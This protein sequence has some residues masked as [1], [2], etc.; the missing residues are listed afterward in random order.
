MTGPSGEE[1]AGNPAEGGGRGTDPRSE[2]Q[3]RDAVIAD[4][5]LAWYVER[6]TPNT[7]ATD[8]DA[9]V[10][11]EAK[12]YINDLCA[13]T[14]I[15]RRSDQAEKALIRHVSSAAAYLRSNKEGP[16]K[17]VA[18][19]CKW[20]GFA[21]LAFMVGQFHNVTQQISQKKVSQTGS[22][23]WLVADVIITVV[24]LMAGFM[25][26]KPLTKLLNIVRSR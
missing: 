23:N 7:F 13:L 8:V 24:F 25:I 10:I 3:A 16:I 5:L 12:D 14:E 2:T 4:T 17:V 9:A 20:I 26:E 6:L 11:T 1:S 21:W 15:N 22:I 19:W 18:D